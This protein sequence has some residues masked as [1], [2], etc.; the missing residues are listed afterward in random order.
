M[1]RL[2]GLNSPEPDD[3]DSMEPSSPVPDP[4]EIAVRDRR[5][6]IVGGPRQGF[7]ALLI[8][9]AQRLFRARLGW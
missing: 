6:L 4:P 8:D 7:P 3:P 9:E 2:S 5:V 1:V